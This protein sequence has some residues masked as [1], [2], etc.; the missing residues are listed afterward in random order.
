MSMGKVLIAAGSALAA[1]ALATGALAAGTVNATAN[2]SVTVIA[3]TS[4][5]K[6]QDMVFG[7]VVRPSALSS[8]NTTINLDTLDHVTATG[9]DGSVIASTTNS[10]KFVISSVA[11][12]TYTLSE[13]LSFTQPGLIN[14]GPSAAVATTGTLGDVPAGGNQEI[15]Y[16]GHFDMTPSTTPQNYTGTLAVTVTYN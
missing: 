10:A 4:I 3:P 5:T 1:S 12:I 16:G 8:G 13:T 7:A 2:A 15:R 11:H 6:T 14:V 9:G